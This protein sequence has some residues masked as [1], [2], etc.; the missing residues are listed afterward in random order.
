M[1]R[2]SWRDLLAQR[3]T[4]R[5]MAA[6]TSHGVRGK[7]SPLL[8]RCPVFETLESR[9]VLSLLVPVTVA[10]PQFDTIHNPDSFPDGDGDIYAKVTIGNNPTRTTDYFT[11]DLITPNW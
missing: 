3:G 5:S 7:W 11:G 9:T 6:A 4:N 10:I 2:P 1:N 8:S